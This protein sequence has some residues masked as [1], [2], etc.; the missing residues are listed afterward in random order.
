MN[1]PLIL[2]SISIFI[3][4]LSAFADIPDNVYKDHAYSIKS[5]YYDLETELKNGIV[6]AENALSGA[7]FEN[8][9][10]KKKIDT[11]WKIR[12]MAWVS[13]G[14]I[15]SNLRQTEDSLNYR[16]YKH[17]YDKLLQIDQSVYSIKDDLYAIIKEVK[18]AQELEKQYQENKKTCILFWCSG[19]K[20]TY[21][22]I[23]SKIQ[24]VESKLKTIESKLSLIESE[25][26][27]ISQ[28]ISQAIHKYE[29]TGKNLEIKKLENLR[30]QEQIQAVNELRNQ[31]YQ[32]ELE[33]NKLEQQQQ[34]LEEQQQ[35]DAK[36]SEIRL[37]ARDYPLLKGIINGGKLSFWIEPLP[38]HV[39]S[40]VRKSV[41]LLSS[42]LDGKHVNGVTL[43][44]VYSYGESD[45][46]INWANDYSS[47]IGRQIGNHLLVGLG[48]SN[49]GS[50]KPFDA[51]TVYEIAYHEVGHVL[52]Q[53]HSKNFNNVMYF[54]A[55]NKYE[56]DYKETI[57]LSDGYRKQITFCHSGDV[58]FITEKIGNSASYEAYVI[59]PSTDA[60]DFVFNG[61]G[62]YYPDCSGDFRQSYNSISKDCEN[63]PSG[64]KLV[65]YN[66]SS[67]GTGNDATIKIEIRETNRH[68]N[69]DFSY[70]TNSRYFTQEYL[71]YVRNLFQ[72]TETNT[73]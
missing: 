57:T 61:E 8:S 3:I 66:P 62:T 49:C 38:D 47:H 70:E 30:K 68:K 20:D 7:S 37:N 6:S 19:D 15:E 42:T 65:L 29:I 26:N 12:Q 51:V 22:D 44:R 33:R 24:D 16:Y 14:Q 41:D 69:I 54:A 67:F 32:A 72:S 40:N 60:S 28:A 9:D 46:T 36:K 73:R 55:D 59:P 35:T 31:Q 45:F 13:N 52:G 2:F 27:K 5:H 34:R 50:W 11:A 43:K 10:A 1:I 21:S 25:K 53:D 39:S 64:S 71:D 56:Y 23:D 48:S 17:S 18:N 63:L 4:P 58:Y